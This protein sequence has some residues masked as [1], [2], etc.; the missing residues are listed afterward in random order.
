MAVES[1]VCPGILLIDD[2]KLAFGHVFCSLSEEQD[3]V[4]RGGLESPS[5]EILE[6]QIALSEL[7]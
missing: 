7:L 5:V 2:N 6:T 1:S 4:G 3:H